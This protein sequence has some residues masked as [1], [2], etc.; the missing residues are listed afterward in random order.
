MQPAD[1]SMDVIELRGEK[2]ALSRER[3]SEVLH[4]KL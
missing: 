3:L 1:D 2:F 4:L